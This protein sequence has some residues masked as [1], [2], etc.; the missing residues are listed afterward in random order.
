MTT[1]AGELAMLGEYPAMIAD[2]EPAAITVGRRD[3]AGR[4]ALVA[5][6]DF[7]VN[8]GTYG[9]TEAEVFE[10]ACRLAIAERLPLVTITRSGGTRLQEGMRALVGIPRAALALREVADAGLPH[11]SVAAHP[12]TGGVWVAIGANADV[13]AAV[14]EAT[15][16]FSGP[17]VVPA[18][19]GEQ[20]PPGANTAESAYAAGLVDALVGNDDVDEWVARALAALATDEPQPVLAPT[21]TPPPARAGWAQVEHSRTAPRP[22]GRELLD[23]L[24]PDGIALRGPDASLDVRIGHVHGRGLVAVAGGAE[25]AGRISTGGYQLLA[26]A[27]TLAGRLGRPLLTLVD[28][29]GADPFPSS[30]DRGLATAIATALGAVLDCSTP[31]LA[32]VHGAGGSGGALALA[33][34]DR[35]AVTADGWFAALGPEGAAAALRSTPD[36]T[37]H[38]MRVAPAELLADGFADAMAPAAPDALAAW[39]ATELDRLAADRQRMNRR[40][41]RWR[42]ALTPTS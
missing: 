21:E 26:R 18:M 42:G 33:V 40:Q 19:T 14:A 17:R 4:A 29:A 30:E 13:R 28:T 3:F 12:T 35:V 11:L 16:G 15:I 25:R 38:L 5:E 6:W 9:V 34:T 32:V 27:A 8:G 41:R 23:A 7:G 31:T 36:A 20:L 24:F 37:A 39:V 10:S 22:S 2:R 1:R